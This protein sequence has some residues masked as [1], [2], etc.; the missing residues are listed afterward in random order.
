MLRIASHFCHSDVCACLFSCGLRLD[1]TSVQWTPFEEF[2][3]HRHSVDLATWVVQWI[4]KEG[5][6]LLKGRRLGAVFEMEDLRNIFF[7]FVLWLKL[8]R[9]AVGRMSYGIFEL[10]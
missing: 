6:F 8:K 9:L 2:A 10:R 5:T 7:K 3:L 1:L 4:S